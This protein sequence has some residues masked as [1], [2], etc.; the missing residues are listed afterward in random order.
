M[1]DPPSD[2]PRPIRRLLP[3]TIERIAA[4]EVVERPA[5]VVKELIENAI[6]A[7]AAN[8]SVRLEGGGTS[9]IEVADDGQGIAADDLELAVE[10]HATSKLSPDGPVEAIDTLGF[11]GEALASIGAVSRLRLLS[12]THDR[13]AGEGISVV[14]GTVAGR[15][16]APRAYGTTVEVEDLFFNTPA[17]QKFQKSP[18]SEQVEVV[19]TVER[20]YLARPSVGIRVESEG[21]EVAVYPPTTSLPDAAARV[22]GAAFLTRS[23]AVRGDVPG[24]RLF[25]ACA[26]PTLAA[27]S[28]GS[29]YVAANGRPIASRALTQAVRTAFR[30]ALPR[31]RYPVGVLHLELGA[32]TLDVNVHPTKRE[33]RFVREREVADAVLR[34]VREA[35]L[36]APALTDVVVGPRSRGPTEPADASSAPTWESPPDP[37]T[38]VPSTAQR[39]L[40]EMP[41]AARPAPVE[42]GPTRPR[43][44]LL[45]ALHDLYWVAASDEGLVV[46]D[47]HAVSER[48][49]F[50][51]IRR[52]RALGRQIL[53]DPVVLL[54]S[55]G[56]RAALAAHAGAIRAAGFEVEPFG[57]ETYRVRSV[58]SFRGRRARAQGVLE[59]LDELAM[60]ARPT[61]PDDLA[62]RTAATIACHAAI[63]AGDVVA[64]D[65]VADLLRALD[66]LPQ[67]P[68]TCPHGRPI[69]VRL[70]RA[71]LDRWFLRTG[72]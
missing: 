24:G 66:G 5:S 62:D 28:P 34:R 26:L 11:R 8:V 50:E 31:S 49:L 64:R 15:F 18:A 9:R 32:D 58:P 29:L 45:G 3:G 67:R 30:D 53:V 55:G 65:E 25:G 13:D 4:G 17:R 43:L 41:G 36:A 70:A 44:E 14:G 10:R 39:T 60:G 35:L 69:F 2:R 20:L 12:R 37:G 22:V 1:S 16:V 6:D 23:F 59:L 52:D 68:T 63:R 56:Q 33:V 61:L 7:G 48:L 38:L 42:E 54:L 51:S 40:E 47:Q 19:R 71:Q 27:S 21:R 46:I 72:T 57:P